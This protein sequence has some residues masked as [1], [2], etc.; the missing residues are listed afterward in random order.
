MSTIYS[1]IS[2]SNKQPPYKNSQS[3]YAIYNKASKQPPCKKIV[4]QKYIYRSIDPSM[5]GSVSSS[6]QC[7]TLLQDGFVVVSLAIAGDGSGRY[8]QKSLEHTHGYHEVHQGP[9]QTI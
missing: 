2:M 3:I 6:S 9:F 1:M 7:T 5:L 4:N 8:E